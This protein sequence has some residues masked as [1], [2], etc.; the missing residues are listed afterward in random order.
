MDD[1]GMDDGGTDEHALFLVHK[2]ELPSRALP[3]L[4]RQ[5]LVGLRCTITEA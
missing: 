2:L 5:S 4:P 1:G 3:P